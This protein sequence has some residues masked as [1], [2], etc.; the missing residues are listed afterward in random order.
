VSTFSDLAL[1]ALVSRTTTASF[2]HAGKQRN[3][4][5]A[6][7]DFIHFFRHHSMLNGSSWTV[8]LSIE[9]S[10][11]MTPTSSEA[12]RQTAQVEVSRSYQI[13]FR[14]ALKRDHIKGRQSLVSNGQTR[15]RSSSANGPSV[16]HR[17][18]I[19]NESSDGQV[20]QPPCH[21]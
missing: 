15:V 6:A 1:H 19:P 3:V 11:C 4:D 18:S 17:P 9:L 7:S 21:F 16:Y 5:K 12:T 8:C 14:M 2:M 20:T 13:L 10:L